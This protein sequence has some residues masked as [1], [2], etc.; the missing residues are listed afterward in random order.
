MPIMPMPTTLF[1]LLVLIFT[2]F[3]MSMAQL[4]KLLNKLWP[5]DNLP[6]DYLPADMLE[7]CTALSE[8]PKFT[9]K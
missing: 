1:L 9:K 6:A 8:S 2:S 7:D 4:P 3:G 5:A